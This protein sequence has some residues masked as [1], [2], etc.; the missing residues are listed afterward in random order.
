M[1][2][3]FMKTFGFNI[4]KAFLYPIEFNSGFDVLSIEHQKLSNI[5][6]LRIEIAK[7]KNSNK[8]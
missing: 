5:Y 6:E 3:Q 2:L 8:E 4:N 7:I 1:V